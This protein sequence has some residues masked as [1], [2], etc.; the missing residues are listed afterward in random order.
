MFSGSTVWPNSKEIKLGS[1]DQEQVKNWGDFSA[2]FTHGSASLQLFLVVWI[3]LRFLSF[4]KADEFSV[5]V[6][7]ITSRIGAS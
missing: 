6:T 1:S 5:R 4:V 7:K 2:M 3:F